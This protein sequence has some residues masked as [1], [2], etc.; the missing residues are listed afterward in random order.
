MYLISHYGM[1][2]ALG[3]G[4]WIYDLPRIVE[5]TINNSK[6]LITSFQEAFLIRTEH[7]EHNMTN[8][9]TKYSS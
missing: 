8:G 4:S 1:H 7:L 9:T 2:D 6:I 5:L 3:K